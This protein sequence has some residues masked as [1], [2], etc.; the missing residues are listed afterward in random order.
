[1]LFTQSI[2]ENF[3][4]KKN[5][6]EDESDSEEIEITAAEVVEKLEEVKKVILIKKYSIPTKF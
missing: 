6:M 5:K 2:Y 4:L 3:P 1:M